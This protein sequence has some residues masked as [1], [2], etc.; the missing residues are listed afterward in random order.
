MDKHPVLRILL[1]EDNDAL[2]MAMA[3]GLSSGYLPIGGVGLTDDVYEGVSQMGEFAHGY[4][5]S[6]HPTA[7]AVAL[8]NLEIMIPFVRTLDEAKGVHELLRE[9]G[10]VRGEDGLRVIMMCEIPSNVILADEFLVV[11]LFT[12][13]KVDGVSPATCTEI[14]GCF[15][16]LCIVGTFGE[17]RSDEAIFESIR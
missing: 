10:L 14:C 3:K 8:K 12:S 9:N 1:V 4:T 11:Y 2:R 7:A 13:C 5:Y 16:T 6:G 15:L 17:C